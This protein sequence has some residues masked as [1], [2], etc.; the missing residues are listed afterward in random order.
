MRNPYRALAASIMAAS[1]HDSGL[2]GS[3]PSTS[4]ADLIGALK[5]LEVCCAAWASQ[6]RAFS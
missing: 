3:S 5:T 1:V 2:D 6:P 4:R